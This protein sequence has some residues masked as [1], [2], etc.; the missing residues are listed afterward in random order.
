M[1]ENGVH[2]AEKKMGWDWPTFSR[3]LTFIGRTASATFSPKTISPK[4]HL[5][6]CIFT[7]YLNAATLN[8]MTIYIYAA[9]NATVVVVAVVDVAQMSF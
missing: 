6:F 1:S 4:W 3:T 2:E 9:S 7:A 8:L 5:T